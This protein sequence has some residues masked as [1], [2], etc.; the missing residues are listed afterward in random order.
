MNGFVS[1]VELMKRALEVAVTVLPNGI[2]FV[3]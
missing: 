2:I 3:V 1:P